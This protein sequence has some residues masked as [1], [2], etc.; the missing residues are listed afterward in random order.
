MAPASLGAA[1]QFEVACAVSPVQLVIDNETF[2]LTKGILKEMAF[3]DDTLA[4]DA[5]MDIQPGGQ[6]LTHMHT[7]KH[8]RENPLPLNFCPD[9]RDTWEKEKRGSLYERARANMQ[10]IMKDA[11]PIDYPD[12]IRKEMDAVVK[13]ADQKLN[14]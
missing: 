5:M 12:D 2:R 1:G 13:K 6:F 8:C 14:K 7:L 3:D 4:M 9:A 10:A 11:A